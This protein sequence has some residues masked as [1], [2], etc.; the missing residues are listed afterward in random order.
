MGVV[1]KR[2]YID[3]RLYGAGSHSIIN[4]D[5][6]TETSEFSHHPLDILLP[7]QNGHVMIKCMLIG[8]QIK[9]GRMNGNASRTQAFHLID[10][11][12]LALIQ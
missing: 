6:M 11:K 7:E 8:G 10:D 5:L 12:L 3:T 4:I 1:G 2:R 9:F